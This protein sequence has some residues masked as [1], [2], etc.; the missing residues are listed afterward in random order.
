M[1]GVH[2]EDTIY[3]LTSAQI[4]VLLTLVPPSKSFIMD[5][6]V[7]GYMRKAMIKVLK[8]LNEKDKAEVEVN[9]ISNILMALPYLFLQGS[10]DGLCRERSQMFYNIILN[11][12][13]QQIKVKSLFKP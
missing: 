6:V 5:Q 8:D 4:G 9:G 11:N 13:Y 1:Q 10:K 7:L 12:Q 3:S 2:E